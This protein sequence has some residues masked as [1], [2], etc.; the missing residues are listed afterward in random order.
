MSYSSAILKVSEILNFIK[1]IF[2]NLLSASHGFLLCSKV[3]DYIHLYSKLIFPY[4]L[5]KNLTLSLY[6]S[7]T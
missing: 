3:M 5:E 2:L 7:Y 1:A 6:I 4:T